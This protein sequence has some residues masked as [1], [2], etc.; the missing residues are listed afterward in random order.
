MSLSLDVLRLPGAKEWTHTITVASN[1]K[2]LVLER[3][4]QDAQFCE[5][6][7]TESVSD[8]VSCVKT[9]YMGEQKQIWVLIA[10]YNG[11]LQ[12]KLIK[13]LPKA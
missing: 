3:S 6:F 2:V 13:Q 1:S 10:T 11:R 8:N 12:C 4:T 7:K 9:V 5:M